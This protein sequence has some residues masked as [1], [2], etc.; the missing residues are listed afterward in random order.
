MK[1]TKSLLMAVLVLFY[2]K[3]PAAEVDATAARAVA[4]SFLQSSAS[5]KFRSHGTVSL[6]LAH[7]EPS[8]VL[9]NAR[10][11]YVFN[12]SDGSAFI[13]VAGD[14]RA[15]DQVLAYGEGAMD[16][17]T[18]PCNVR[19][20]L[21]QY[22]RQI[23]FLQSQPDEVVRVRKPR[24]APARAVSSIEPLLTCKW[25]QRAPYYDQCPTY[26]GELCLTGCVAT[27]LAQVMYYWK[28]PAELPALAS[29][30]TSSLAIEV[31]E[32]PGVCLDWDN[33]I[34]V[35]KTHRPGS[36]DNYTP[37]QAAAVATLM[38]YCGQ[39]CY[40]DYTPAA[41]A[42]LVNDQCAAL[43][44]FGYDDSAVEIQ[45]D[46]YSDEQWNKMLLEDLSAGR[47]VLYSGSSWDSGHAF[48][49]D[50]YANG[51]YH[52]NWGWGGSSDGYFS[53]DMLGSGEY[54]FN[55]YQDMVH[56][57][58]P[59]EDGV[60][61][62]I[63]D[64]EENGIYYKANEDEAIVVTRDNLFNSYQGEV[65]IPET[66]SHGGRTY[67]VTAIDKNAFRNCQ[68][69]TGL[70][71]SNTV[72]SIGTSAFWN[73]KSLSKITIG[74]AVDSIGC[75]AFF[76]CYDLQK[77]EIEDMTS[78]ARINFDDYYASP[79]MYDAG[80]YYQGEELTELVIPGNAG[81]IG[82]YTFSLCSRIT[83]VTIGEGVTSIGKYAFCEC[84]ALTR[85]TMPASLENIGVCAFAFDE[86]MTDVSFGEGLKMIDASA[87]YGCTGLKSLSFSS[88]VESI[89]YAA[90]AYCE[91]IEN[92]EFKGG[93][94]FFDEA[95]FYGCTS[96]TD[97]K[98]SPTQ[99]AVDLEAFMY[100]SALTNIDLG[101]RLERIGEYAFYKCTGLEEL[102]IPETLTVVGNNAFD[103]CKKMNRINIGNL[104][105][106]CGIDFANESANPLS[107]AHALF[108]DGEPVKDLVFDS[109]VQSIRRNIF[110]GCTSL[111]S[112]TIPS[113]VTSIGAS[114]FLSCSG[115][116][117]VNA[118]SLT[119]WLNIKF[120][121]EGANPLSSAGHLFVQGEEV[122]ELV[123]PETVDAIND[124]SFCSWEGLTAVTIG[125]HVTSLGNRAFNGCVNLV[126]V[127]MGDGV[128]SIGER[129][130][131]G[132]ESLKSVSMGRGIESIATKAFAQSMSITD[133]TC[134]ASTPPVLAAKDCFAL[135]VYKNATVSVPNAS[136]EAYGAAS[137]WS[138]FKNI[139]GACFDHIVG[140]VNLDGEVTVADINAVINVIM[141]GGEISVADVNGDG[142]INIADVNAVID[143]IFK[144]K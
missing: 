104:K 24:C 69:L 38:R 62:V 84:P 115:L 109:D 64:F 85:V 18:Q 112:V 23:E 129:A 4:E 29:F 86:S 28:Y 20:M 110:V 8:A 41:S 7:A 91:G 14:D 99:T 5:G 134:K 49:L 137:F 61:A 57:I 122:Q 58:F 63:Y 93:D 70:K 138:Q 96:M 75:D 132:C 35:Y 17:A 36:D 131:A 12:T 126:T 2:M 79:L 55:Y 80:I 19:W 11:Y 78:F 87:F 101:Q 140:D 13:I 106:W 143:E 54:T 39:A 144:A 113:S 27:A 56:N 119:D 15:S 25:N 22:K 111:E 95:A 30:T 32:L 89:G 94:V 72:K 6:T 73:C 60:A 97:L 31:P 74:K 3:V 123:V 90:F 71:I 9:D 10:D 118:S 105:A 47:P 128:K 76:G 116:T 26:Q 100:C 46:N 108:V 50:G 42:A 16:V 102:T 65:I 135:I 142:E 59:R 133:I 120:E 52:V 117:R 81:R 88:S 37:E 33:M 43:L 136:L 114:A 40:M 44:A 121:N 103:G 82:N 1:L 67:E 124:C 107:C 48:V 83:S 127:T 68:G 98:L 141:N 53:L 92:L 139:S 66:V 130:F 51:K 45:R 125:D 77:V 34:D 21:E